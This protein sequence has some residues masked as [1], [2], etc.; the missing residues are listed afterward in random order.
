MIFFNV[1]S[2]VRDDIILILYLFTKGRGTLDM[3]FV[4]HGKKFFRVKDKIL[5]QKV[6]RSEN[7]HAFQISKNIN[8]F[9]TFPNTNFFDMHS[10]Y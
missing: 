2:S 9:P 10:A 8:L 3:I 4:M 6:F 7:P 1:T 5:V